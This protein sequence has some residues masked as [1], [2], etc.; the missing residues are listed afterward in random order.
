MTT[1]SVIVPFRNAERTIAETAASLIAQDCPEWEALF[2]DD[3]SSDASV[4]VLQG[5][6]DRRLRVLSD[7]P[8]AA[9]GAARTRNIGIRA[10]VGRYVA[11]LDADDLWVPEKL[12]HQLRAFRQHEER[13]V[14]SSYRRFGNAQG[15][16]IAKPRVE[17]RDALAGNP[18]GCLTGAFDTD[19]HGR[20]EMPEIPMHEDYAFWLSLLRRGPAR[21]L[22]EVLAHY[23]VSPGSASANK[24]KGVLAV[25]RILGMQ[26]LPPHRRIAGVAGHVAGALRKRV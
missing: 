25:W 22:P 19:F 26:G 21:G 23:R 20:A 6:G 1:F 9:R 13:I 11:F 10:S 5:F 15:I 2:V 16:V 4:Q 8:G 3:G 18:I 12:S 24:A 7:G 17:W 14:F